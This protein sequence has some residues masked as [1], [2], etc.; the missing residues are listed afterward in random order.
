MEHLTELIKAFSPFISAAVTL[1]VCLITQNSDRKRTEALIEYRLNAL[2]KEVEKHNNVV[3]RMATME[4]KQSETA[5]DVDNLF[6]R[7]RDLEKGR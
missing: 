4:I 1:A 2:T 3:E 5:K 7:V 6:G